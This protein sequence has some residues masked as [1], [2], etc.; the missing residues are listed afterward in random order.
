MNNNLTLISDNKKEID[1]LSGEEFTLM[2]NKK[3][4]INNVARNLNLNNFFNKEFNI[5]NLNTRK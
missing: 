2:N 5:N 3:R 1:I 4:L